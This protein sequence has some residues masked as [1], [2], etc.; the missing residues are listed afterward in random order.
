[1][2]TLANAAWKKGLDWF[3]G[4]WWYIAQN[5]WQGL[6]SFIE[7]ESK[8][9]YQELPVNEVL[10]YLGFSEVFE[11]RLFRSKHKKWNT[12]GYHSARVHQTEIKLKH[13]CHSTFQ[14]WTIGNQTGTSCCLLCL[15][16]WMLFVLL[17]IY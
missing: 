4:W 15:W 2:C 3:Q 11:G 16:N 6:T 1:M 8:M 10:M 14:G 9:D 12:S 5:Y 13:W 17:A 7:K